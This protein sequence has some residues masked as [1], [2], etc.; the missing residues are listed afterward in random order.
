[1]LFI[2]EA[3]KLENEPSYEEIVY[4]AG[5]IKQSFKLTMEQSLYAMMRYVVKSTPGIRAHFNRAF[6]CCIE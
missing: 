3:F 1:M 6:G 2:A 4:V 5:Q